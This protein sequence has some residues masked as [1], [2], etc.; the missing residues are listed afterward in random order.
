MNWL[1]SRTKKKTNINECSDEEL[2]SIRKS[3]S[4]QTFL[5]SQSKDDD[6]NLNEFDKDKDE[7]DEDDGEDEEDEEEEESELDEDDEDEGVI[8]VI[9]IK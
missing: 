1:Q 5:S 6:F 2:N 8:N 3:P 7:E 9:S 4:V